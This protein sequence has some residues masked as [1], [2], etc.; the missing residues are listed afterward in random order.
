MQFQQSLTKT[1]GPLSEEVRVDGG[2]SPAA[3]DPHPGTPHPL[4]LREP[5][6][7]LCQTDSGNPG[8][9]AWGFH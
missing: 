3:G 1:P 8:L 9:K 2:P 5:S 7:L 6:A 4:A